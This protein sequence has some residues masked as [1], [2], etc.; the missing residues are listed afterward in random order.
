M[1][2]KNFMEN[3]GFKVLAMAR[4]S[5]RDY[6]VVLYLINTALSELDQFITTEAELSSLVGYEEGMLRQTLT[7]LAEKNIIRIQYADHGSNGDLGS[8]SLRIGM[9]YDLSRWQMTFEKDASPHDAIVFPFRRQGSSANLMLF[10]GERQEKK[11]GKG[12]TTETWRRVVDTFSRSRE[13]IGDDEWKQAEEAA[14]I[15]VD[16]HPVD[17]VLLMIRHF[18]LRIPTLSLLASSWQH[19]QEIFENETQKVD[20]MEARQKHIELDSRVREQVDNILADQDELELSQE[21]V[22]VLQILRNHRHPRRQ[23]FWA[24]QLRSRYPKLSG[25]FADNV[26]LMLPVTTGGHV[27]KRP[28]DGPGWEPPMPPEKG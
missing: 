15:L 2:I 12:A 7:D 16:T 21:E 11:P 4:L 9:N 13:I 28:G 6:S 18:G 1:K 19:Y 10:E 20:L 25:F 17:Q 23:L 27:V 24:Y 8:Q 14:K 3:S 5:A 26:H 22:T